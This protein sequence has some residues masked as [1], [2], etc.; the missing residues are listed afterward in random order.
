MNLLILIKD[1]LTN[2]LLTMPATMKSERSS[3]IQ[4]KKNNFS[5]SWLIRLKIQTGK[6]KLRLQD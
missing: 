3:F 1:E 4:N 6:K 2:M 5:A